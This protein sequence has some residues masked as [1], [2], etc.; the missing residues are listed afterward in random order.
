MIY[1]NKT[2]INPDTITVKAGKLVRIEIEVRDTSYGCMS[3][4][5]IPGLWNKPLAFVKG[6]TLVMEFI[7]KKAGEYQIT[8]AMGVP[9]GT[10]KVVN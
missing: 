6:K 8:C 1:T 7:P 3:T 4:I 5:M 10:V 9:R 2:D